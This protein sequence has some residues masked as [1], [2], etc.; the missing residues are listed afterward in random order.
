MSAP[1]LDPRLLT[2]QYR[3]KTARMVMFNLS[4]RQCSQC[5]RRRSPGRFLAGGDVCFDC[6]RRA[7]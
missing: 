5:R 4:Q 2:D 7:Q 6:R 3:A 1:T